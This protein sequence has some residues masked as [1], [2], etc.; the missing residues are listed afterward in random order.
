MGKANP[1]PVCVGIHFNSDINASQQ[2][3]ETLYTKYKD[4]KIKINKKI[5]KGGEMTA[6]YYDIPALLRRRAGLTEEKY[7]ERREKGESKGCIVKELRANF[8][9]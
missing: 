8:L 3:R 5:Q 4:L 1:M 9:N 6:E 2:I 7:R